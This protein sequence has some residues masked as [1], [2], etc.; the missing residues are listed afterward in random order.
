[1]GD[2]GAIEA[3]AEQKWISVQLMPRDILSDIGRNGKQRTVSFPW[4]A[5]AALAMCG[6]LERTSSRYHGDRHCHSFMDGGD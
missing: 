3:I 1:V 5:I 2:A 4:D 6:P